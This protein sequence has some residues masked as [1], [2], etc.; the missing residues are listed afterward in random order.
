MFIIAVGSWLIHFN[1]LAEE[2][3]HR[4]R[5]KD[6]S[7]SSSW[8]SFC[9]L[10]KSLPREPCQPLRNPQQLVGLLPGAVLPGTELVQQVK[11]GLPSF[12]HC[13]ED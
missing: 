5:V 7:H 3:S 9:I 13:R 4:K 10:V 8:V 12:W 1:N 2:D 11:A 6:V